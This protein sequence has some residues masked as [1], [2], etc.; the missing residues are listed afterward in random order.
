[1]TTPRRAYEAGHAPKCL[2]IV[3]DTAEADRAVRYAS[4]WALRNSGGVV[5]LRVIDTEDHNQQ[6]LG[7][8]DIMRA[9][10]HETA[11]AALDAAAARAADVAGITP[12]RVIREGSAGAQILDV[13]ATDPDI[14]LLV[15]A[16]ATGVE[17]PGPIITAVT[18]L[19]G[20]FPIPVT[21]V[22]GNLDAADIA[23]LT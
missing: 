2:V 4:R 7:V 8:A 14:V 12:A 3:D 5:M 23:A 13:I 19:A 17:G 9:E 6:W 16:A 15:L 20:T 10:A 22:P 21:L 1:M 11:N 18:A